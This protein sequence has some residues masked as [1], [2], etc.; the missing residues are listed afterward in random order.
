[1]L[2]SQSAQMETSED[3]D[4]LSPVV[5]ASRIRDGVTG[6]IRTRH[7]A[8]GSTARATAGRTASVRAKR[9]RRS[10]KTM[11]SGVQ[12]AES[13]ARASTQ[14]ARQ[15][16]QTVSRTMAAVKAGV[17]AS[18]SA[19][20][21]VPFLL[22]AAA[23]LMVFSLLLWFIPT[24]A[25]G[26]DGGCEASVIEVPDEAKPWV[27]EAA[28]SSGL[29][30]DFI[31]AIMKQESGFRSDAYADDSNGGTWGLLQ[32]NRSVWRGVHPDGTDRTP[33]EGITDPMVHAHY[34]GMYLKNRLEG[35]KQLKAAHPGM[36]FAELDDLTALVIA[37]NAGEGN[38]MRYPDIPNTTKRYLDNVKPAIDVGVGCSATAGRTIGKL[39]P[40]LV[41]QPGTLNVDVAATGTPV[42]KIT[43]YATGQ[44]T[45]WA[46][47]RR[48]Q[49]GK[50]VD[51]YMGDG[52]MWA[53]SARKFGYPTGGGIQLGDVAS[54]AKGYLGA[55]A[56]YGHVAIVE[57][58]K[59]DGSIVV[60]ESGGGLP[61]AWLRTLT[62][63]QA[64][65]PSITY[66]H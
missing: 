7:A 45:W 37:H 20:V 47:A 1:M 53:S 13:V 9:T 18:A 51:G 4:L 2:E 32:M 42:G 33:P 39:T 44:C 14:V 21:S 23:V 10:G 66:I 56:D 17:A 5:P 55:S 26:D 35:V 29:S 41:M 3:D 28:R 22:G 25:V 64:N 63:E 30:A 58:I 24:V 49:I 52:W 46:A 31:A 62:K 34:G 15:V 50:P 16:T 19:A 61:Y 65:N 40:P 12:G 8:R 6:I 27:S 38:L 36:P 54:F 43:T 57:E 60:S 59:D 48:L 11:R